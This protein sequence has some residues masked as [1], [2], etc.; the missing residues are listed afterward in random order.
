[1]NRFQYV[2]VIL[3]VMMMINTPTVLASSSTLKVAEEKQLSDELID[4]EKR[5]LGG[6]FGSRD[7]L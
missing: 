4:E 5:L 3:G 1:M 7:P 2:I 6:E